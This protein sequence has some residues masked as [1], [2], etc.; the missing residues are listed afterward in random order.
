[1]PPM[2]AAPLRTT[3]ET[4]ARSRD[5][6]AGIDQDKRLKSLDLKPA[7]LIYCRPPSLQTRFRPRLCPHRHTTN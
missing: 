1:M 6:T 4:Q 5:K 3:D 7:T 2:L